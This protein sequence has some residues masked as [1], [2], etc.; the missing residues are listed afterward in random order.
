[1]DGVL[2]IG[3][4]F[5]AGEGAVAAAIGAVLKRAEE[6]VR[7]V[8]PIVVGDRDA[9]ALHAY[10]ATASPV[11]AA[12]HAGE[13]LNPA[14][15]VAELREGWGALVAAVPGGVLG[16]I[17]TRYTVRD[18]AAELG[19]PVVLAM[20]AVPDATTLVRLSVA[21]ARAARLTIVAVVLTGWPDPPDRVQLDERRLLAET[22]GVSVLARPPPPAA[23]ADVVR[24][25]P[26]EDWI[27][28]APPPAPEPPPPARA[29]AAPR[30]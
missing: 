18:L 21:A 14:A 22:A 24:D 9:D 20:P 25:W 2:V 29:A 16:A 4:Q 10:A 11:T 3:L 7:V 19:L 27:R 15:L 6:P 5:G 30:T 8:R 17:T 13:P 12:R 1:M 23:R 28:A 26:V